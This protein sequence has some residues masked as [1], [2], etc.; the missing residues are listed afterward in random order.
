[1]F[2]EATEKNDTATTNHAAI[3]VMFSV[4]K[5]DTTVTQ[6]QNTTIQKFLDSHRFKDAN[7]QAVDE[8]AL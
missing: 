5:F 8:I 3:S 6:A 1:M 7:D 4:D 2:F